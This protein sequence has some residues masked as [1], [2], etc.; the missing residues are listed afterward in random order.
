MKKKLIHI[1]LTFALMG[2]S[3][4]VFSQ[5]KPVRI[6][7]STIKTELRTSAISLGISYLKSLDSLFTLQDIHQ[8]E[9]NTLFQ[10][11][12]EFDVLTGTS[13]AFS[14]VS[15][16]LSGIYM[17]FGDTL[18]DGVLTPNTARGFQT[19]PFSAGFETNNKF[20]V[21]NGIVEAGWVPWYQTEGNRKTPGWLKHTKFGLF[22]QAGYKFGI[23]TTGIT[24]IGGETDQSF[25]APDH[26]ILRTKGSF[27]IDTQSLFELSGVGVGIS[28]N[29][30]GWYDFLNNRVY[31]S[32]QGKIRFYLTGDKNRFFDFKYQKG[33]GA[34]NFNEGDQFG[35]G[36]TLMF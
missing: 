30:D 29:A 4:Q 36:L 32:V 9:K 25:E 3:L 28:G 35:M 21:L 26:A 27:G 7:L 12:P 14:S 15:A 6:D 23:D 13:D 22:V 10:V 20:N 17:L 31:Y 16:R 18:I 1:A 24:T 34:P 8:A 19:F 33:S 2:P 5:E 11:T